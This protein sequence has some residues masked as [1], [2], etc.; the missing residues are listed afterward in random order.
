MLTGRPMSRSKPVPCLSSPKFGVA[1]HWVSQPLAGPV[2]TWPAFCGLSPS[3]V[4][5]GPNASALTGVIVRTCGAAAAPGAVAVGA[6]AALADA[7]ALAAAAL[8]A[9]ALAAARAAAWL[10]RCAA[11]GA[12]WTARW[13]V[14]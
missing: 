12:D 2:R 1:Y 5:S 10:A 4:P 13:L 11:A 7:A 9:E 6:A 3:T 8:A 14:T